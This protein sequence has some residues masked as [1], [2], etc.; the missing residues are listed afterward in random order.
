MFGKKQFGRKRVAEPQARQ[1][2]QPRSAPRHPD[3]PQPSRDDDGK[4]RAIPKAVFEGEQ[5]KF[6]RDLGFGPDDERNIIPQAEDFDRMVQES[7]SRQEE[8]RCQL[9]ASLLEKYG[10]NQ[11]RPFFICGEGVLNT[12]FGNWLIRAMKL[13]PYDEWN[14]TYLPLDEATASAMGLPLHPQQSIGPIDELIL[15]KLRPIMDNVEVAR[16]R[17]KEAMAGGYDPEKADQFLKY[18]DDQ[19]EN[20]VGFVEQ[21][22]PMIIELIA[23]VQQGQS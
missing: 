14:T 10:H 16:G 9:E 12:S 18:I 13:M 1:R 23:E 15:G 4:V 6:L 5:G 7:L 17:S 8:R 20:I 22:K 19:R 11:I 3:F 2:V 21:V